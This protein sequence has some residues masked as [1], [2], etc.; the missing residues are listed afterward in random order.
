M[1]VFTVIHEEMKKN[2]ELSSV[3]LRSVLLARFNITAGLENNYSA[4]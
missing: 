4:C 3:E 2:D 1:P